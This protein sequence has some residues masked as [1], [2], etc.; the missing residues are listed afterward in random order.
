MGMEKKSLY[1]LFYEVIQRIPKG[2][3][4]TYGQVANIAGYSGYARQVGYALHSIPKGMDLPWH[5]V[6]NSKGK[7]SIKKDGLYDNIQR[8]LLED[9]GIVFS[10]R[11][12]V[13]LSTYQ[14]D[15][16]KNI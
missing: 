3:V 15:P 9:E 16:G 5:R 11:N 4:A 1:F 14:W 7:I 8:I 13:S 10:N 2:T 12:C 6:I